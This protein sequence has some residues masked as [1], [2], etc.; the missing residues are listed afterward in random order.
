M[1]DVTPHWLQKQQAYDYITQLCK[2]LVDVRGLGKHLKE[3]AAYT[4][5]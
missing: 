2:V 5:V 1:R 3:G 4:R